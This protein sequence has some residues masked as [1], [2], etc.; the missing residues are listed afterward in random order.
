MARPFLDPLKVLTF[1]L[2]TAEK[3]AYVAIHYRR[4]LIGLVVGIVIISVQQHWAD[5]DRRLMSDGRALFWYELGRYER[6][7]SAYWDDLHAVQWRRWVTG[8]EAYQ[9]LLQGQTQRAA[10]AADERLVHNPADAEALLTKG[11][12]AL[13]E[14]NI[15]LALTSFAAI[16]ENEPDHF[17]AWL[18]TAVAHTRR[19]EASA[20][21][22]ALQHALR[23]D[24]GGRRITAFIWALDTTGSLRRNTTSWC[25]LAYYYRYL[26][27]FDPSNARLAASAAREA[28][29]Q[30][31][32][33]DDAYVTLGV[34]DEKQGYYDD[35]LVLY[36]TAIA[37]NRR[38]A[39][40]YRRAAA[41]Y[42]HRG[43]ALLEE[44]RMWS[45]ASEAAVN[46][47]FYERCL[48]AFLT[49]RLG[50]YSQALKRTLAALAYRPADRDLQRQAAMIYQERG[51]HADALQV[52]ESLLDSGLR[53]DYRIYYDMGVSYEG[54]GNYER[55]IQAYEKALQVNASAAWAHA[56][57]GRVYVQERRIDEAIRSYEAAVRLN[58]NELSLRAY[59]C[60]EYYLIG[61][62]TQAASCFEEVLRR[63]PHH[64]AAN[65]LYPYVRQNLGLDV[66]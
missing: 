53:N 36:Q 27:I 29:K 51:Q 18:L 22:N 37:K 15:S 2:S 23:T 16:L 55:A 47:L 1:S 38:N 46:D 44:Y 52:Y 65:R 60:Q 42:S 48:V 62:Y 49:D 13:G 14:N 11:E 19:D 17:D 8:D 45:A 26:R 3:A 59:L 4:A 57:L 64:R 28:I 20:A 10:L 9:F 12:I 41:M 30:N 40:A 35:A 58:P 6:A 32:R 25:L 34:L 33:P 5:M 7:A 66:S 63:D 50:D 21:I 61:S 39:E 56:G 43:D 24:Q 31:D 54:L